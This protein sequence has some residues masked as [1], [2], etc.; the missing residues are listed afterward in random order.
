MHV[1]GT[2]RL[3]MVDE[4][5]DPLYRRLLQEFHRIAGVPAVLNTSFNAPGE[6]IVCR[7]EEAVADLERLGLDALALGPWLVQRG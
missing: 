1:D 4:H 5:A 3:H 2:S 6:P 7:P